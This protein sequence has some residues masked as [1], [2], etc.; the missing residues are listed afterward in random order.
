MNALK[1]RL[2]AAALTLML[3]PGLR[4]ESFRDHLGLQLYSLRDMFKTNVTGALDQVKA[5]GFVEVE[6]AGTYGLTPAKFAALLRERGLKAVSAHIGYDELDKN[7]PGAVR[8]ARTL[9]VR[10]VICPYIPHRGRFDDQAARQ[11]AAKF[12]RWGAAF[13]AA[14]I[15]FGYHTHGFEFFPATTPGATTVFDVLARDTDPK[16]VCFEMDVFWVYRAGVDPVALLK[17]YPGRWVMLHV[18]DLRRGAPR[19]P[20]IGS[21][22]RPADRVAVGSGQIDWPAVLRT[23][24]KIGV[25]HYF[26]ED[27]SPDPLQCIP[28]GLHWLNTFKE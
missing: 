10:Y 16:L 26:I 6:T 13:Q 25:R 21:T 24:E 17:K 14:G 5:W 7:L 1:H 8:E 2:A 28:A 12:N 20:V 22:A 19:G 9:G 4:A 18:K 27:E 3:V 23:A 11:T 15:K